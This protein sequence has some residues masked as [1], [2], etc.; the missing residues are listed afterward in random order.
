MFK[1]Y[2]QILLLLKVL[3][4]GLQLQFWPRHSVLRIFTTILHLQ[5]R[6]YLF[7][8]FN[9][10][11]RLIKSQPYFKT[12]I[13][14]QKSQLANTL[15]KDNLLSPGVNTLLNPKWP[16][17]KLKITQAHFPI[18]AYFIFSFHLFFIFYKLSR[19]LDGKT[20]LKKGN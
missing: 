5:L 7:A 9:N 17:L 12:I 16:N 19:A 6:P 3:K 13:V 1:I 11:K 4:N 10:I 15:F 14:H 8:I 20:L 18:S 2:Y